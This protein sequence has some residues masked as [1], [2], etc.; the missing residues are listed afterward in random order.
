MSR[1]KSELPVKAANNAREVF[2]VGDFNVWGKSAAS[3]RKLKDGSF[4]LTLE[5]DANKEYQL[6]YL[7][8]GECWENDRDADKYVSTPFGDCGNSVVIAYQRPWRGQV[9]LGT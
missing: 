6:R 8:G 1:V 9:A 4:I 5:L 2:V 7:I 3:M